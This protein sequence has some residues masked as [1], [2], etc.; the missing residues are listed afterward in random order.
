M[1]QQL[2][3]LKGRIQDTFGIGITDEDE[4]IRRDAQATYKQAG[5][6][7]G[8]MNL[9]LFSGWLALKGIPI[10]RKS[11]MEKGSGYYH[12]MALVGSGYLKVDFKRRQVSLRH[13]GKNVTLAY[14]NPRFFRG[15][16]CIATIFFFSNEEAHKDAEAVI[17]IGSTSGEY[18][19]MAALDG[20][21][22]YAVEPYP[23][24]FSLIK[25]N[26]RLNSLEGKVVPLNVAIAGKKGKIMLDANF[27]DTIGASLHSS[28]GKAEI[29]AITIADLVGLTAGERF[30]LKCNVEGHEKEIFADAAMNEQALRNCVSAQIAWHYKEYPQE[31]L[32]RLPKY[33]EAEVIKGLPL[34][35]GDHPYTIIL[36][37]KAMQ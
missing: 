13:K 3:Q 31:L 2:A 22:A 34:V 19:I 33:V 11:L 9:L 12:A 21:K 28:A 8:K 7:Q 27:M 26:I 20:K 24:P 1:N 5:T 29:E 18:A 17:D 32:D 15:I 36:K 6:F 37:Q 4:K 30:M 16:C 35:T 23:F 14:G 25:E 10:E